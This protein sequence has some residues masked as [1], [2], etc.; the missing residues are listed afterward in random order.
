MQ[1]KNE[2]MQKKITQKK[3]MQMYLQVKELF[4]GGFSSHHAGILR[5]KGVI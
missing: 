1:K 3:I 4:Q 2:I 5:M